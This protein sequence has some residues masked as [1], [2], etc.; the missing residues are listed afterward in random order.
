MSISKGFVRL[1]P[2][3][4]FVLIYFLASKGTLKNL[5]CLIDYISDLP[6]CA[7]L[8]QHGGYKGKELSI[9]SGTSWDV[10]YL[11]VHG[12]NDVASSLRVNPNCVFKGYQHGNMKGHVMYHS[13]DVSNLGR[14]NNQISSLSCHCSRGK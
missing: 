10:E 6:N 8:F 12:W 11:K 9:P 7:V 14:W 13:S 2:E 5:T 1:Q 3:K 4:S